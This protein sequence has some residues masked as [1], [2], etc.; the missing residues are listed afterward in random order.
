MIKDF[1]TKDTISFAEECKGWEEAIRLC[2]Y[3][4]L[5]SG[6]I[7]EGYVEACIDNVK[8]NGPYIVLAPLVAMPH[9]KAPEYVKKICM[10]YLNLKK[11]VDV[12]D[13]PQRPAKMFIMLAAKDGESHLECMASLGKVLSDKE[14]LEGLINAA[15]V[16]DVLEII[17]SV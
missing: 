1:F 8:K 7:E 16:E 4:L 5:E 2:G 15:C 14:K 3:P 11:P 10:S 6:C 17:G 13:N 9:A 12:L